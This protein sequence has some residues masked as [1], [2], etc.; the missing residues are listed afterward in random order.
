MHPE[1]N[2]YYLIPS[3]Q[4]LLQK[5]GHFCELQRIS[6]MPSNSQKLNCTCRS[7]HFLMARPWWR[8]HRTPASAQM[9]FKRRHDKTDH[10]VK[11]QPW[12][13]TA[14]SSI[15]NLTFHN[16]LHDFRT[17]YPISVL[18]L[19]ISQQPGLDCF[20]KTCNKEGEVNTNR[21]QCINWLMHWSSG[22]WFLSNGCGCYT[23][24]WAVLLTP[25]FDR[26]S[27]HTRIDIHSRQSIPWPTNRPMLEMFGATRHKESAFCGKLKSSRW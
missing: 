25:Q 14:A 15:E 11:I 21:C 22:T 27:I 17:D 7:T 12:N 20:T 8:R 5:V 2:K 26:F 10:I 4:H 18:I 13:T 23:N 1:P 19:N 24:E 9:V 16:F 6:C 3:L